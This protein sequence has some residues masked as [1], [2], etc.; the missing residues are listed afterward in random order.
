MLDK[1]ITIDDAQTIFC[2]TCKENY[3]MVFSKDRKDVFVVCDC[4]EAEQIGKFLNRFLAAH[5]DGV[6]EEPEDGM[7]YQ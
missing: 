2:P 3:R 6:T 7:M 4:Y 1:D 5:V